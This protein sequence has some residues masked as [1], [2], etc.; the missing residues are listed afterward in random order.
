MKTTTPSRSPWV[1]VVVFVHNQ[2][3]RQK[4]N[5]SY[6]LFI[7]TLIPL[8]LRRDHQYFILSCQS[9]RWLLLAF[10]CSIVFFFLFLYFGEDWLFASLGTSARDL[11]VS[12]WIRWEQSIYKKININTRES[13][14]ESRQHEIDLFCIGFCQE[15]CLLKFQLLFLLFWSKIEEE[16]HG[17]LFKSKLLYVHT[18]CGKYKN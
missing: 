4:A 6:R 1:V 9:K 14:V 16:M 2:R 5:I 17:Y 12:V 18:I 10:F 13:R 15:N 3:K 11:W 8:R 7:C